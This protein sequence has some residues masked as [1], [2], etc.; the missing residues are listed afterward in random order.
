MGEIEADSLGEVE[1]EPGGIES[2]AQRMELRPIRAEMLKEAAALMGEAYACSVRALLRL[3]AAELEPH[4]DLIAFTDEAA[5]MSEELS[6][7]AGRVAA[8][9]PL[10]GAVA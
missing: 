1:T 8:L 2:E 6:E 10:G 4:Q 3:E 9:G 7:L 5:V